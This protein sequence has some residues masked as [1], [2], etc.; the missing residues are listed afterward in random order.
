MGN[1][2]DMA[3]ED[4]ATGQELVASCF[5]KI[6]IPP[7]SVGLMADMDKKTAKKAGKC[8]ADKMMSDDNKTNKSFAKCL[9]KA[10]IEDEAEVESFGACR[11][12]MMNPV[13]DDAEV[14]ESGAQEQPGQDD[15][16]AQPESNLSEECQFVKEHMMS[17]NMESCFN[18]KKDSDECKEVYKA[19]KNAKKQWKNCKDAVKEEMSAKDDEVESDDDVDSDDDMEME[20]PTCVAELGLEDAVEA[21][22][23]KM[24]D[25]FDDC[26]DKMDLEMPECADELEIDQEMV[27]QHMMMMKKCSGD[28]MDKEGGKMDKDGEEG[29]LE[30]GDEEAEDKPSKGDKGNKGNK[31]NK[32]EKSRKRRQTA[33]EEV[34]EDESDD[35]KP[36]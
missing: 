12:E 30:E 4:I 31:G 32:G 35:S 24:E 29:E 20:L 36:S 33:E 21:H 5:D 15:D 16:E 8:F 9:K 28:K 2:G 7:C 3:A 11:T 19:D 27:Q 22:M 14:S 10:G 23:D 1:K 26:Y 18:E 25:F 34:V 13:D 17:M 6:A